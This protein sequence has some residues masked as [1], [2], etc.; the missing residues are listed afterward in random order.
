MAKRRKPAAR[1]PLTRREREALGAI[2]RATAEAKGTDY[3]GVRAALNEW[4]M[5]GIEAP[6]RKD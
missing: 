2:H 6:H 1:P 3:S 4:L 5:A